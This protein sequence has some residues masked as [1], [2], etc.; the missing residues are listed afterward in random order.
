MFHRFMYIPVYS[1]T[2][3]FH[4]T[5]P[6]TAGSVSFMIRLSNEPISTTSIRTVLPTYNIGPPSNIPNRSTL[7]SR[8]VM[9]VL[10]SESNADALRMS[11]L[12]SMT[13]FTLSLTDTSILMSFG[14]GIQSDLT[15]QEPI[16]QYPTRTILLMNDRIHTL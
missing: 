5:P 1:D 16:G 8:N 9:N 3:A 2:R 11:C 4:K 14:S 7:S 10:I 6:P 13:C 12:V 15:N